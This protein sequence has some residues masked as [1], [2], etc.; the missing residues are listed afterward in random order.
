MEITI[1]KLLYFKT[2]IVVKFSKHLNVNGT[3]RRGLLHSDLLI[4]TFNNNNDQLI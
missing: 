4:I 2:Y 3:W 1:I